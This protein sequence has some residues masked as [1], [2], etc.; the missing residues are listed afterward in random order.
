[1]MAWRTFDPNLI[2]FW[3]SFTIVFEFF[4]TRPKTGSFGFGIPEVP[5]S[6]LEVPAF[7]WDLQLWLA[8]DLFEIFSTVLSS[9]IPRVSEST[10]TM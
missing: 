5:V 2:I 4:Q 8:L 3:R 9:I 1:M 7:L 10:M 6:I